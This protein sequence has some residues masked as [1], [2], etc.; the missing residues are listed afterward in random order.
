LST[1]TGP[2]VTEVNMLSALPGYDKCSLVQASHINVGEALQHSNDT[3]ISQPLVTRATWK[4][5]ES[6]LQIY[7]DRVYKKSLDQTR[8]NRET[9]LTSSPL[10]FLCHVRSRKQQPFP[11]ALQRLASWLVLTHETRLLPSARR[12]SSPTLKE[13]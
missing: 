5:C 7:H 11:H 6:Q 2:L 12:C 4:E 3:F 1:L 9:W 8:F 13:I 10:P